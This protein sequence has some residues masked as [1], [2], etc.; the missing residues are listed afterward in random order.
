MTA[1]PLQKNILAGRDDKI[2]LSPS[3]PILFRTYTSHKQKSQVIP[4]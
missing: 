4:I 3:I 2:E 1:I